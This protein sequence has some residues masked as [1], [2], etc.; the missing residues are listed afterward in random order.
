MTNTIKNVQLYTVYAM[1]QGTVC[2]MVHDAENN[3]ARSV[4]LSAFLY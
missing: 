3:S 1:V 4:V 2:D